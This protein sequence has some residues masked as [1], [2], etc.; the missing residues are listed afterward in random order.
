VAHSEDQREAAIRVLAQFRLKDRAE[1]RD[2]GARGDAERIGHWTAQDECA[3]R[4]FEIDLAAGLQKKTGTAKSGRLPPDWRRA[5]SD[6]RRAAK[7]WNTP[8]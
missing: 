8:A 5:Q 7:R 2:A 4:S 6:A 3:I 1:R